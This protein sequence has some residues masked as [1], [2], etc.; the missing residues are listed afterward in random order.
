MKK[1]ESIDANGMIMQSEWQRPD[2][3]NKSKTS[4]NAK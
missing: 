2:T 1:I 4:T 3:T